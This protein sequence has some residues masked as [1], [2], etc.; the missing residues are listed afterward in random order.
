MPNYYHA[1]TAAGHIITLSDGN[2]KLISNA[3]TRFLIFSLPAVKTCPFST[4]ECRL[5]CYALKAERLYPECNVSR[6]RNHAATMDADFVETMVSLIERIMKNS[7]NF[8]ACKKVLFR[9]HESGDFYSRAYLDKWLQ[10]AA[11]VGRKYPQFVFAAYTK[12]I[13]FFFDGAALRADIP[14]NFVVSASVWADTDPDLARRS[15]DFFKVYTAYTADK[16]DALVKSGEFGRCRCS[17]CAT[18]QRC[19]TKKCR[20]TACVIH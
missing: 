2:S 10:I 17:D 4:A 13:D 7:R 12:S 6:A 15:F 11:I 5:A 18:C 9:I 19:Y 20:H 1:T 14:E 16:V 8:K 3:A